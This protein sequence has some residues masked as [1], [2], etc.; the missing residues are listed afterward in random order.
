MQITSAF[1]TSFV[2]TGLNVCTLL[3]SEILWEKFR[4]GTG[5]CEPFVLYL[6]DFSLGK[7]MFLP[8]TSHKA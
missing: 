6:P 5:F 2:Q 4:F 1:F 3:L 8:S 7:A